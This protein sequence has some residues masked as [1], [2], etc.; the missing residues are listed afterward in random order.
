[1][2]NTESGMSGT[3]RYRRKGAPGVSLTGLIAV[4][5][6]LGAIGLVVIKTV[7]AYIEYGAV[8]KAVAKAKADGGDV[9]AM[10]ADFD[11]N[12]DINAITAIA[13]RDL[14]IERDGETTEISFGYQKRIPLV[15]NVS[16]LIDFAGTTDPSGVAAK[17][18]Q[19]AK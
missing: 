3:M 5:I 14:V 1:M 11:R 8:K 10:R 16:L 18:D 17:P 7:P 4:L 13:G 9:R 12:A 15:S 19:A 6:V 2:G